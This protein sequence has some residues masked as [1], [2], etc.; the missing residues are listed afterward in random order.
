MIA[1]M[2]MS[3]VEEVD[4]VVVMLV[5]VTG[6]RSWFEWTRMALQRELDRR[7]AAASCFA[8]SPRFVTYVVRA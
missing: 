1:M 2:S 8:D 5:S 6:P 7:L 3:S 4:E